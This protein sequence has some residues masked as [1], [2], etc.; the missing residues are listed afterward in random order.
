[1]PIELKEKH[2]SSNQLIYNPAIRL[3]DI[4]VKR[5]FAILITCICS[6]QLNS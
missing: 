4:G 5:T 1:M 6:E 3:Y 2:Q